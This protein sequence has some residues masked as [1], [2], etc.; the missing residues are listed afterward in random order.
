MVEAELTRLAGRLGDDVDVRIRA[1][2]E[3][4]VHRVV[5][6]LL[7]T[8]T[9]RI[10]QLAGEPGGSGYAEALRELFG[11]DLGAVDAVTSIRELPEI[12]EVPEISSIGAG[13]VS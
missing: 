13:G 11:L 10:K 12:S 6:K 1:E 4:T 5:E 3:Q 8:P 7:H 9:V 2:V